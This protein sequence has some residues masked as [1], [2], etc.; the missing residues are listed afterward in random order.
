MTTTHTEAEKAA[1][2]IKTRFLN[3][4]AAG[5]HALAELVQKESQKARNSVDFKAVTHFA[6]AA[7]KAQNVFVNNKQLYYF[8]GAIAE[9]VE[10]FVLW[11]LA[12]K[13]RAY[14]FDNYTFLP[15]EKH[16]VLL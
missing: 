10:N 6:L 8:F 4:C 12:E 5:P 16:G 2:A 1:E 13:A 3:A 7:R 15:E 11:E 14:F 9:A